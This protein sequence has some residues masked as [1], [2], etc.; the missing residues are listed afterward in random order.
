MRDSR[1]AIQLC[2]VLQTHHVEGFPPPGIGIQRELGHRLRIDETLDARFRN[3]V[4]APYRLPFKSDRPDHQAMET[5]SVLSSS[6]A[7]IVAADIRQTPLVKL[8]L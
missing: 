3:R 1:A 6:R 5:L 4:I 8:L 7:C 2:S